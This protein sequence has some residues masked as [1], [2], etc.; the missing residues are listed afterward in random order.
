MDEEISLPTLPSIRLKMNTFY[1]AQVEFVKILLSFGLGYEN[2]MA[3][4]AN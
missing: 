1:D 2:T 4:S 3:P